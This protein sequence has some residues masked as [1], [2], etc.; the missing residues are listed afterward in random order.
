MVLEHRWNQRKQVRL[1]ALVL[2]RLAGLLQADILNIGPDGVFI[3]LEYPV[4]PVPA[5]VHLSFALEI[6]GKHAIIQTDA[7]VIH[8][9][10]NGYGM[11]FKDY[12][13]TVFPP[14]KE[15]LNAA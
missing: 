5:V 12:R 1:N 2:H 4:L 3:A 14:P 11:M 8:R 6:A 10:H 7:F 13:F 15:A 9:Q